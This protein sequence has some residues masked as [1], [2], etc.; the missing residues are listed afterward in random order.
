[1]LYIM[2]YILCIKITFY[3]IL[4]TLDLSGNSLRSVHQ[5]TFSGAQ[6]LLELYLNDN[7]LDTIDGAFAGMSQ[8]SR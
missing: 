3:L 4:Q 7:L 1:M 8:L 5:G 6:S 2:L